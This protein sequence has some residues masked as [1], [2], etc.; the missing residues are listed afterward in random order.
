MSKL[1][2][3]STARQGA[4]T[5]ALLPPT[6]PKERHLKRIPGLILENDPVSTSEMM[7]AGQG[8]HSIAR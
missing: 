2:Y 4:T 6:D 8:L 1:A 7:T 5:P 3:L